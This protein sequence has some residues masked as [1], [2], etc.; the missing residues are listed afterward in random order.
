MERFDK[1]IYVIRFR[2]GIE[3]KTLKID[4][5]Q[6]LDYIIDKLEAESINYLVIKEQAN[7]KKDIL[8]SLLDYEVKQE[9]KEYVLF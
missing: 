2:E 8:K 1:T 4:D 6:T 9:A 3:I 5:K 7:C